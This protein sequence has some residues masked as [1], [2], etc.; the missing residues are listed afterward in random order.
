MISEAFRRPAPKG[1]M[2]D[3]QAESAVINQQIARFQAAGGQIEVVKTGYT[4]FV[5]W[6]DLTHSGRKDRHFYEGMAKRGK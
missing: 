4:D 5:D 2:T 3:K 6:G 1:G